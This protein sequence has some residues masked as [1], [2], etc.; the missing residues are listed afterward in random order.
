VLPNLLEV[1]GALM[2]GRVRKG[3]EG[4]A[5]VREVGGRSG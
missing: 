5:W 1:L 3:T 4:L 2:N